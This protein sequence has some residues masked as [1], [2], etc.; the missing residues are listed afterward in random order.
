MKR[1]TSKPSPNLNWKKSS[2]SNGSGGECLECAQTKTKIFIRDS[3]FTQGPTISMQS[4]PW[5]TFVDS[6]PAQE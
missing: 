4:A 3:K 6:L 1:I 2:Y 5:Q